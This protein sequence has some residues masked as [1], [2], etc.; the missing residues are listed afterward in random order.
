MSNPTVN[1]NSKQ[2]DPS[3]RDLLDLH[4][5]D[6]LLSLNCHALATIQSFDSAS[7]KVTAS[8]NYKKSIL[9]RDSDGNYSTVLHDYPVLLDMPVV[10]LG[11][12]PAQVTFP[13]QAG[14]TCLVLFNDR[15]ID[16]WFQSGQVGPVASNRLHSFADGIALVG[17]RSQANPIE[18]Y[19]ETRA[20]LSWGQTV[21]QVSEDKIKLANALYTLNEL[22]QELVTDINL[23][24]TQ[25]AALTVTGVTSGLGNS[26]VPAN[27]AAI[28]AVGVSLAATAVKIGELLE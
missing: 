19:D 10:I 1:F 3:L 20:G 16:N 15:D 25:T 7:L 6:I 14:D 22:L 18:N 5:K 2:T 11:G 13:I 12:G 23:L 21:V 4:K 8:M 9:Q 26:G 28:T 17:V 27:A 24:V